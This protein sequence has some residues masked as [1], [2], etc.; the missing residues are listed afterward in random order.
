MTV[1]K[2]RNGATSKS[3]LPAHARK[4]VVVILIGAILS[5]LDATVVNVAVKSLSLSLNSSLAVIQW[6]VTAYLLAQAAVLP[7]TGWAARRMGA[8]RLYLGALLIFTIASIWCGLSDTAGELIAARVVQGI[9]GGAMLPAG[10]MVL[11]AAAG[12]E[13][14]AKVMAAVGIPMV[15]TPVVGPTIGGLL[16]EYAGWPWIFLINVPIGAAGLALGLWLLPRAASTDSAGPLDLPGLMLAST[17]MV[18]L[19]Y[20][21]TEIGAHGIGTVRVLIP[22]TA[23]LAAIVLFATRALRI[24]HPLLDLR[25]YRDA[26][27]SSAALTTFLIG[28]ATFGAMV[29]LPLYFQSVRG[30]DPAHTGMLLAPQGLGAAVA[31]AASS[32]I[33][34]RIGSMICVIGSMIG[35]AAT[36]PFLLITDT[37][38]YWLL[39]VSMV[40][41]GVG[42]GL[43]AMPAMTVALRG[44]SPSQI[45]DAT[46]QLNIMQRLGG[47]IGTAVFVTVLGDQLRDSGIQSSVQ[48][49]AFGTTFAWVLAAA[50]FAIVPTIAMALLERRSRLRV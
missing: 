39:G 7:V 9:G 37:T 5:L 25:L 36:V 4:A 43:A 29:L 45:S 3:E 49:A 30:Q 18:G 41:R 27:F 21:L 44:L 26:L 20:G 23:G 12:S 19:T 31:M 47:S 15:L 2:R 38:P 46:P 6:V 33:F 22:L 50:V 14:L 16:L 11:V 42:I 10:Q 17:G 40:M 8:A 28:A 1:S 32:R 13:G 34:D 35:V 48:A 24:P